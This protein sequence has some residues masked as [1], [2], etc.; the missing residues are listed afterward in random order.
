MKN[1]VWD[2]QIFALH[3]HCKF[4]DRF[5]QKSAFVSKTCKIYEEMK[6]RSKKSH[7]GPSNG[8]MSRDFLL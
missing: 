1:Y 7:D 3:E 6:M 5:F 8:S 4:V 2:S